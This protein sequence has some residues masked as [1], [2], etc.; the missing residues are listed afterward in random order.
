L[1]LVATSANAATVKLE[2][3]TAGEGPFNGAIDASSVSGGL[4]VASSSLTHD[5]TVGNDAAGSLKFTID[6]DPD[7]AIR[8]LTPWRVNALANG[9]DRSAN[10]GF[11]ASGHIG[12]WLRT[13]SEGLLASI[14]ID[15][16]THEEFGRQRSVIADGQWHLY[17]WNLDASSGLNEWLGGDGMIG[18]SL[19]GGSATINALRLESASNLPGD[20]N[21]IFWIDDISHNPNGVVV[22]EPSVFALLA[23]GGFSLMTRDR[24]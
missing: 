19:P 3:F 2:D 23:I 5:P 1:V 18:G 14:Y 10:V 15:D 22:P 17:Q 11:A 13:T 9:G 8:G 4:A 7:M 21:A 24:R 16:G 20:F 6:D 12:Y